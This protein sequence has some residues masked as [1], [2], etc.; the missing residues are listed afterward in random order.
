MS[1]VVTRSS[2][3]KRKSRHEDKENS[4]KIMAEHG[5]SKNMKKKKRKISTKK[6]KV[7]KKE[8]KEDN[9]N[10]QKNQKSSN[11]EKKVVNIDEDEDEEEKKSKS[12]RTEKSNPTSCTRD[13]LLK[14]IASRN[15][16]DVFDCLVVLPLACISLTMEYACTF[17]EMKREFEKTSQFADAH[18]EDLLGRTFAFAKVE[19]QM[20]AY[21]IAC[22]KMNGNGVEKDL[23]QACIV[24]RKL[25]RNGYKHAETLL[26]HSSEIWKAYAHNELARWIRNEI[27][28]SRI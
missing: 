28:R 13:V 26:T 12:L 2:I 6:I 9:E 3:T 5:T 4:S 23:N 25:V 24:L 11:S 7:A 19:R 8:D 20:H 10:N 17:M 27:R 22:R 15:I 14:E 21:D 1:N 18:A 16:P